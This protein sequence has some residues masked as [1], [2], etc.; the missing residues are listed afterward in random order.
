MDEPVAAPLVES[1]AA[2]WSSSRLLVWTLALTAGLAAGVVG[3]LGGEATHDRLQPRL[4]ATGGVPSI[5]EAAAGADAMRSA[6]AM[7]AA[8]AFGSLGAASGLA[9]GLAGGA[10]QRSARSGLIGAVFGAIL[11]ARLVP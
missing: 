7:Q 11:G 6:V 10:A 9:L 1:T 3:W 4:L 2:H 8:A 5:E